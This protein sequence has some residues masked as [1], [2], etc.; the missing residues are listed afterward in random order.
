MQPGSLAEPRVGRVNRSSLNGQREL[1]LVFL[2]S[3]LQG[4]LFTCV[5][6]G[7]GGKIPTMI[8][9]LGE[10]GSSLSCKKLSFGNGQFVPVPCVISIP[11]HLFYRLDKMSLFSSWIRVIII[12]GLAFPLYFGE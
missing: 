2:S 10:K 1:V 7:L 4:L 3:L 11:M 6:C 12:I 5:S 8:T 9:N